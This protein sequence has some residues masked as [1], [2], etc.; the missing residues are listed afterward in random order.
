MCLVDNTVLYPTRIYSWLQ[1]LRLNTFSDKT[2][3]R[4]RDNRLAIVGLV[5]VFLPDVRLYG[6]L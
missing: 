2:P 3:Q 4:L 1:R 6:S 5:L